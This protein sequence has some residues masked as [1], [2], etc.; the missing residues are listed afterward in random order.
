VR[1]AFINQIE[2]CS[3]GGLAVD[4]IIHASQIS[5]ELPEKERYTGPPGWGWGMGLMTQFPKHLIINYAS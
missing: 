4:R 5:R 2:N 3:F 1:L